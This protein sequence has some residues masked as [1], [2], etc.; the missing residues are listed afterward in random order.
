MTLAT[1]STTSCR[2]LMPRRK[3]S[4]PSHSLWSCSK[5][6]VLLMGEKPYAGIPCAR[7]YLESVPAGNISGESFTEL[8]SQ[9]SE[10]I[11]V[12]KMQD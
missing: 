12:R 11:D 6:G 10:N 1:L 3:V 4:T 8:L 9:A 2:T 7:R 5:M